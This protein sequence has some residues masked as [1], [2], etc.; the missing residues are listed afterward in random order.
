MPDM[1]KN[2]MQTYEIVLLMENSMEPEH[3]T[4]MTYPSVD[5]E[6]ASPNATEISDFVGD[7]KPETD[8]DGD[9]AVVTHSIY[10]QVQQK[11]LF[12]EEH[13]HKKEK[14]LPQFKFTDAVKD[15]V[16]Y[17]EFRTASK[18]LRKL[19]LNF[20][21]MKRFEDTFIIAKFKSIK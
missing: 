18:E 3:M 5:E 14:R 8:N 19:T 17:L 1:N 16:C 21:V 11:Y 10:W 7:E 15:Y 12:G 6:V 9:H 2:D 13:Y 20:E 4:H